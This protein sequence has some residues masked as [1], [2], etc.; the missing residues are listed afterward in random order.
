[1]S[2]ENLS[3]FNDLNESKENHLYE[4][5]QT[6]LRKH[7]FYIV[8]SIIELAID[9]ALWIGFVYP[10]VWNQID[11]W[12]YAWTDKECYKSEIGQ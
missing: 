3:F 11:R 7:R 6:Q 10:M 12:Q 8:R 9:L 2:L 5:K 1:M 4:M